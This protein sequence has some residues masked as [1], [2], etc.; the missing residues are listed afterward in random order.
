MAVWL[1]VGMTGLY[2]VYGG[3]MSVAWT[4]FFQCVL[5]L[6]GGGI[7]V[8]VERIEND[9]RAGLEAF[10]ALGVAGDRGR[11]NVA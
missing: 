3:L 11:V 10:L 7:V 5:L 2:T 9:P 8:G 6:G 1:V 4:N